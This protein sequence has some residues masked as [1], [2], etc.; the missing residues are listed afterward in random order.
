MQRRG[1]R[2]GKLATLCTRR[3][4]LTFSSVQNDSCSDGVITKASILYL[5][6]GLTI[7]FQTKTKTNE[8]A[9]ANVNEAGVPTVI[10]EGADESVGNYTDPLFLPYLFEFDYADNANLRAL[11]E[12]NPHGVIRFPY[13]GNTLR[14]FCDQD[15]NAACTEKTNLHFACKP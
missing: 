3:Q 13:K 10:D 6:D 9:V 1:H 4:R 14:R 2:I 5:L 8:D 7:K 11:V 15:G 12:A